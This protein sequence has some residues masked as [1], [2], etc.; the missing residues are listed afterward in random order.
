MDSE[1][2]STI[3][4]VLGTETQRDSKTCQGHTARR[5]QSQTLNPG[6]LAPEAINKCGLTVLA[7]KQSN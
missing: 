1:V 4:L 2:G 6:R 3:T 5:W 7:P